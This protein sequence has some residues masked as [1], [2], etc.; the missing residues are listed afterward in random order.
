MRDIYGY[1]ENLKNSSFD[2]HDFFIHSSYRVKNN[3]RKY[4]CFLIT[5][6]GCGMIVNEMTGKKGAL[7]TASYV[8]KF[9]EKEAIEKMDELQIVFNYQG[10][11]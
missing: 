7:F 3:T 1:I 2:Y 11:N 9:N 6:D 5:R 8:T 4:G 10:C